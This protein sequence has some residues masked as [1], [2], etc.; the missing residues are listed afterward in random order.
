S[1]YLYHL[2]EYIEGE[3]LRVFMD[4]QAPCDIWQTYDL[5]TKIG[6][7]VRVMHRNYLLHQDIKPENILLT[8]SGAVKLIDFGSA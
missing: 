7:A 2:T 6:M 3:S 1:T 4:R 5:L 8:Q